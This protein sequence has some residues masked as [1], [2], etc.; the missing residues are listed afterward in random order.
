[1][2]KTTIKDIARVSGLSI[3]TV[4]LSLNNS[5][6][7][8]LK[9]RSKVIEIAE[10]LNYVKNNSAS[11]L[12]T[13]QNKNICMFIPENEIFNDL[14]QVITQTLKLLQKSY[15]V[16][17]YTYSRQN[18]H[19]LLRCAESNNCDTCI[20]FMPSNKPMFITKSRML[21]ISIDQLDKY[22]STVS[23]H[24]DYQLMAKF[25]LTQ[26]DQSRFKYIY[27]LNDKRDQSLSTKVINAT[28]K[29]SLK[30]MVNIRSIEFISLDLKDLPQIYD[31]YSISLKMTAFVST[32]FDAL[33]M[34]RNVIQ[35]AFS[36]EF[37]HVQ[38]SKQWIYLNKFGSSLNSTNL[39]TEVIFDNDLLSQ[40]IVKLVDNNVQDAK[41]IMLSPKI[42]E[43]LD[44]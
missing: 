30:N 28:I 41:R 36:L 3:A 29:D 11:N 20:L 1:M 32:N 16:L 38:K 18:I 42:I 22:G 6:K 13:K 8:T 12:R 10:E 31:K 15:N 4:S 35:S 9:T 2:K 40:E 37:E 19:H 17:F 23:I 27:M 34:L 24:P 39:M 44:Y 33:L 21:I 43:H 5:P 25:A 14:Q 26:I 7:I